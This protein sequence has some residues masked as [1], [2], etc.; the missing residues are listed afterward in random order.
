[1]AKSIFLFISG[2]AGAGKNTMISKLQEK[3]NEV[4]FLRS[5][6]SRPRR[7]DDKSDTYHYV[8]SHEEF[9][10]LIDNGDILE[11]DKFNG[12]YY[13]ISKNEIERLKTMDK[14]VMKDLSV[15]GVSNLRGLKLDFV[16]IFLTAPKSILKDRLIKRNYDKKQIKSRLN[17]YNAE[18]MKMSTYDYVIENIEI[19]LT[20]EKLFA[21]ANMERNNL[22]LL[23]L[24]SCQNVLNKTLDKLTR[25]IEKGKFVGYVKVV[26]KNNRVYIVEG[27]NEYLA[28]LK[29]NT[30]CPKLFVNSTN[31]TENE[32]NLKEWEKLVELYKN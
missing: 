28:Y 6:T 2:T 25:K 22:P 7:N 16:S 21:I 14:I 18:Q 13:G 30:H 32:E 5:H 24:E 15:L 10:K 19:D 31:L 8:D 17:L 23:T 29:T 11:F 9:E 12:N 1:M 20:A 27:I 3:N 26:A 4:H